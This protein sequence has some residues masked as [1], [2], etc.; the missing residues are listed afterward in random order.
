MFELRSD[1]LRVAMEGAGEEYR[2]SRFDWSGIARQVILDG[3]HSFCAPEAYAPGSGSGGEG[4]MSEFGRHR[5]LGYASAPAGGEF[6]RPGIGILAKEDDR[7]F[8]CFRDYATRPFRVRLERDSARAL[9][10]SEAEPCGGYA[11]R[12]E[13]EVSVRDNAL[14]FRV[15]FINVG[16][17]AIET[18]EYAH[19]FLCIDGRPIG[20]G[21]G[22]S[23]DYA[24]GFSPTPP[25]ALS[26]DRTA[27]RFTGPNAPPGFY[28]QTAA[29]AGAASHRWT[30]AHRPSGVRVSEEDDFEPLY[31]A[32][33]GVRH[34]ISPEVLISL[35]I[36][37]GESRTWTRTYRFDSGVGE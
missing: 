33:W 15:R 28:L 7:P 18:E 26:A 29:P 30:L 23:V 3:R 27:L 31:F 32:I 24:M 5:Q 19:N 34:V 10:I 11:F 20:E 6:A 25:V 2:R 8:N 4:L 9:Y 13:K 14:A 16:E 22:L 17:R 37:P 1:R 36:P 35:E 12:E 21:Y